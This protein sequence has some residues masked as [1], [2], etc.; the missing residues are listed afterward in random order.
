MALKLKNRNSKWIE[1]FHFPPSIFN[2]IP[3]RFSVQIPIGFKH[4][5]ASI[6]ETF[7]CVLF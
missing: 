1:K 7:F 5:T 4:K 2:K 6:F 3:E